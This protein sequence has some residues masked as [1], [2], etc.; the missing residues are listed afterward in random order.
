MTYQWQSSTD[1]GSTW[2]DVSGA[3]AATYVAIPTVDTSYRCNVTCSSSTGTST[4]VAVAVSQSVA[5][6]TGDTICVNGVANL[7]T[8]GSSILNWY[9]APTGGNL[10]ATGTSYSPNVTAT[11]TYYVSSASASSASANTAAWGGASV[12]SALFKGIAFDVTNKIKLK[13][14]T[15]YPKN[16]TARTPITIALYDATGNVVAG[17]SPVTFTPNLVTVAISSATAQVVN[18]DYN[19]PVGTGYRLVVTNGLVATTN[20]LGNS[21]GAITYPATSGSIVLRGNVSALNDAINVTNNTTNC[22]HNL[23]FD[24]ICESTTRTPVIATVGCTKNLKL[25]IEG[26]YIGGGEMTPVKANEG[27]GT[28]TTDV[29]DVTVELRDASTYALVATTSAV[30]KTDGSVAAKLVA[31]AGNYFIAVKHRNTIQTW[32]SAAEAFGTSTATY[33]FSTAANKAYGDNM[34]NLG[35]GVFGF[36]SGDI[37]QDNS[38]D[39]ADFPALFSDN[40][41]FVFGY[42]NTDLNGDGSVDI[43]DFPVVFLNT[44][45]FIYSINPTN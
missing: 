44:D 3:T 9:D 6:G 29:D 5:V 7:S 1:A 24:E 2:A 41:N 39:I 13:T 19:I 11:T 28:S 27:V 22:F 38:I 36:Y 32:S 15:V 16:T 21:T 25:F 23:T 30:L 40:D 12:S 14:V 31:P 37:N 20:T 42:Y 4:P 10:V 34:K 35:S 8:S 26:Y 17:T 43:A 33:D 18:L 45:N